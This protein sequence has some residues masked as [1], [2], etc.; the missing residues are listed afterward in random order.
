[1]GKV[2]RAGR[3]RIRPRDVRRN[4]GQRGGGYKRFVRRDT[5]GE[6]GG[7][8]AGGS[9]PERRWMGGCK[10]TQEERFSRR[11]DERVLGDG[12]FGARV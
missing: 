9:Y 4:V 11:A 5:A 7:I 3:I 8:S 12:D 10:R 2:K 6:A 1:M